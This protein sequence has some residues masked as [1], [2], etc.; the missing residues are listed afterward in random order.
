MSTE[1]L[2]DGNAEEETMITKRCQQQNNN[3]SN[4]ELEN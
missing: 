1:H 4:E 2:Y 3:G